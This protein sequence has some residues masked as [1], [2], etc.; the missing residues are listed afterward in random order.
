MNLIIHD[1]HQSTVKFTS[2][3]CRSVLW[4]CRLQ[5]LVQSFHEIQFQEMDFCVHLDIVHQQSYTFTPSTA[6]ILL[7]APSEA[8]ASWHLLVSASESGESQH[9]STAAHPDHKGQFAT[10]RYSLVTVLIHQLVSEQ[11]HSSQAE[12]SYQPPGSPLNVALCWRRWASASRRRR[13]AAVSDAQSASLWVIARSAW[14]PDPA[15]A[16]VK[17]RLSM[18]HL[19]L[20]VR[21]RPLGESLNPARLE[22]SHWKWI[23]QA[24]WMVQSR[25]FWR[26]CH[27][28]NQNEN[29]VAWVVWV[30]ESTKCFSRLRGKEGTREDI[31]SE[32]LSFWFAFVFPEICSTFKAE[33]NHVDQKDFV[34]VLA[35]LALHNT[36][37]AFNLPLTRL[38]ELWVRFFNNFQA[39]NTCRQEVHLR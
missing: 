10:D 19:H 3:M 37:D 38:F 12:D 32:S 23:A 25:F 16:F 28:E 29:L 13:D 5:L 8:K 17:C 39:R 26:A 31:C 35:G 24:R 9:C 33:N 27:T 20:V 36:N 14:R 6:S 18:L 21:L 15:F 30:A 7:T 1:I 4:S 2:G 34:R 22:F 11:S